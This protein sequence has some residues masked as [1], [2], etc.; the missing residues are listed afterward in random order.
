M[1]TNHKMFIY[2]K[3]DEYYTPKILVEPIL[4]YLKPNSTIW[5][6]FDTQSSEF[7]ILLEE[8]GHEVIY[9]H[10]SHGVDFFNTLT[11][12]CDYIISNPPFTKK[13]EVFKS[14]YERDIP[15]AML[16]GLPM[17]NYQ[18]ISNFFINKDL[19][20]LIF[21]KKISFDG[22]PASFATAYFCKNILPKD[23][24]FENLKNTNA[25]QYFIKSRMVLE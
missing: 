14:L 15:F 21:N 18:E 3:Q 22:N 17:L 6:P 8:A 7:V 9:S 20:L 4:K 16:G 23:L 24:I 19:Q 5:C 11:V 13:L 2:N 10:I 12:P 25:K 1:K